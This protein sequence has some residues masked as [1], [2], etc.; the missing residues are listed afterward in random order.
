MSIR[1]IRSIRISE[2]I[3]NI[4]L[5]K[6]ADY[7]DDFKVEGHL[8]VFNNCREQGFVLS[9]SNSDYSKGMHIWAYGQRNSDGPTITWDYNKMFSVTEQWNM[10]SED[11]YRNKTEYFEGV[12]EAAEFAFKIIKS[13][14][15]DGDE[16][17]G[18]DPLKEED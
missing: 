8:E 11:S 6:L 17:I 5:D 9:L 1:K 13:Y 12:E 10:Y 14:F 18:H 16:W 2:L 15:Q 4:V 3:F 7:E